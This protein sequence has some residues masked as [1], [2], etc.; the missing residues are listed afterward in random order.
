MIT[1][2]KV[3]PR[4]GTPFI[5]LAT[6]RGH[7]L[8]EYADFSTGWCSIEGC[9]GGFFRCGEYDD[10]IATVP[11]NGDAPCLLLTD[12]QVALLAQAGR[13]VPPETSQN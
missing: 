8:V 6:D 1:K 10:F 9:D 2:L 12:E 11:S 5:L 4:D 3:A 7:A 13:A